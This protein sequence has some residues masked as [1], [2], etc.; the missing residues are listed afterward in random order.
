MLMIF[1]QHINIHT[2]VD[3]KAEITTPSGFPFSTDLNGIKELECEIYSRPSIMNSIFFQFSSFLSHT[4]HRMA[5]EFKE[6]KHIGDPNMIRNEKIC[7]FLS[8][9]LWINFLSL[10]L[11]MRERVAKEFYYFIKWDASCISYR[12]Q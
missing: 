12:T 1:F 3:I 4:Q 10:S 8:R 9:T 7:E 6:N 5:V 11:K 2:L